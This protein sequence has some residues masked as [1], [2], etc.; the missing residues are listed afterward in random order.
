MGYVLIGTEASQFSG[1]ARAYL[2]WKSIDFSERPATPEAYRDVIEPRVGYPVIPILL[3]PEGGTIQ[4]TVDIVDHIE[5]VAGQPSAYPS[6]PVQKLVALLFELYADE[7]L[8]I[9]A[10]HYRWAYNED[11]ILEELGR[12]ASPG[13]SREDMLKFG[14]IAAEPIRQLGPMLGVSEDTISG[15]EAHYEGFLADFSAHLRQSPYLF[16]SRPSVGDFALYGALYGPL[17]RDPASGEIMKRLA[18]QVAKWVE[19]TGNLPAQSGEFLAG[20][21]TPETLQPML[22]R[23]MAEQL[24]VLVEGIQRLAEWSEAQPQGARLPKTIG[25][26]EFTIGG[27]H[28]ERQIFPHSLWRLQRVLD[29]L[30]SLSGA[31]RARATS[32]LDAIGGRQLSEVSLPRRLERR[33]FRIV[34]G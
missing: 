27:R 14:R 2:R 16:G 11:W 4:D 10:T 28:G 23:Q 29:H 5:R 18:P 21:R 6:G 31:D 1:K 13:A 17:Y 15:I 9:A 22:K 7:W 12:V 25:G 26:Q 20:D 8:I 3:T 19:R 24:P 32:L 30:G 33:D 34:V